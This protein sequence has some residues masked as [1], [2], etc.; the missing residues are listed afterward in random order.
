MGCVMKKSL[1]IVLVLSIL[2]CLLA[3]CRET[4]NQDESNK[5][6]E[7]TQASVDLLLTDS[8]M[9]TDRDARKIGRA[10]V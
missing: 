9:F 5:D 6:N 8:D 2:T 4:S 1:S 7:I 10:H 3:G